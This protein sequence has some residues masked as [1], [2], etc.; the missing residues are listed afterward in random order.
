ME[1]DL[2]LENIETYSNV[3]EENDV[4]NISNESIETVAQV[5]K[6]SLEEIKLLE[7]SGDQAKTDACIEAG[8]K[9]MLLL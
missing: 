3:V 9:E 6:D 5:A 2:K 4:K 1:T 7:A 8:V